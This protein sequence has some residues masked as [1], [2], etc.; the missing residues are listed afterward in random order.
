MH[1]SILIWLALP[2]QWGLINAD[3]SSPLNICAACHLGNEPKPYCKN[4]Y[5]RIQDR[6]HHNS[7]LYCVAGESN[8]ARQPIEPGC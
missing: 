1:H 4:G 2:L 8:C 5:C 7:G 6:P 3:C